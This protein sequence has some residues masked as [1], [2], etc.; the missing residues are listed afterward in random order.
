FLGALASSA[1]FF[2]VLGWFMSGAIYEW[3]F[4]YASGGG[5]VRQ[6]QRRSIVDAFFAPL[7]GRYPQLAILVVKDVKTFL[8]DGTQ[9]TQVL[10]FFGILAL[11]IGNL[12]NFSYPLDQPFYQ[13]L[14]SFLNLGA[15]CMTLAT[16]TSRFIFPLISLEGRRFWVLGLVPLD[17]RQIMMSK[18][19]FAFGGSVILTIT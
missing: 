9:W 16:L 3:T 12:R 15:T 10:I 6:A 5:V 1:L 8:R 11:Y 13:N 2:L 14:I 7:M 18:F 4:S 17:R 19:Y